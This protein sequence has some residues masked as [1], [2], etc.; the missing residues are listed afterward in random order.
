M[1]LRSRLCG[2]ER[3]IRI[4]KDSFSNGSWSVESVFLDAE[5]GERQVDALLLKLWFIDFAD[6]DE[7]IV[8][9]MNPKPPLDAIVECNP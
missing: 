8:V 3:A 6:F 7:S 9:L 2:D 1:T 5:D 4:S